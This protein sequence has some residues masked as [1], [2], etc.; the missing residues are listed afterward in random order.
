MKE[1][2]VLALAIWGLSLS[3]AFA[4]TQDCCCKNE[5]WSCKTEALQR[6]GEFNSAYCGFRNEPIACYID[7]RETC[8]DTVSKRTVVKQFR[9]YT[10]ACMNSFTDCD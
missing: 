3:S 7:L 5:N 4:Q 2:G 6:N 10:G 8:V 9:Q 1:F